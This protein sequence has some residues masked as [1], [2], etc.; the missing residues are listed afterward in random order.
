MVIAPNLFFGIFKFIMQQ[1]NTLLLSA[2]FSNE[3]LLPKLNK[4][5]P[6]MN[7]TYMYGIKNIII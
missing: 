5:M 4:Y 7:D 1:I 2:F 3:L 6:K